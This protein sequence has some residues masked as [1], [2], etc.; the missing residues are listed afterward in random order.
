MVGEFANV[1]PDEVPRLL[2]VREVE[3]AINLA[4]ST[5]P[6]SRTLYR[7]TPLESRMLK[8]Q[9]QELLEHGFIKGSFS[10]WGTPIP[11]IKQHTVVH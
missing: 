1:F 8:T 3:C 5:E 9:L 7:M 6:I 10:P 4:L 2:P 11:F